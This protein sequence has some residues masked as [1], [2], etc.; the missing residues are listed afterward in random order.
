MASIDR[1]RRMR[2]DFVFDVVESN[3]ATRIMRVALRPDPRRY[4]AYERGG[5]TYYH[6]RYLG[7]HYGPEVIAQM[8][9]QMV[10]HANI[11]SRGKH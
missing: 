5:K 2:M 6:D 11:L 4:E 8:A 3:D 1:E 9:Q 7:F 10:R